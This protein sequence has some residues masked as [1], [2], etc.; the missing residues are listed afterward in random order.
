MRTPSSIRFSA[1][2]LLAWPNDKEVTDAFR[3][4]RY[5]G[6]IGQPRIAL[7]LSSIDAHLRANDPHQPAA[8]IDYSNLQIEH[9]MPQSWEQNWPVVI[10]GERVSKDENDPAWLTASEE[11]IRA[12]NHL[13]NLTLVNGSFNGH[14][15]NGPWASKRAEFAKQNTLVINFPIADTDGWDEGHIRSRAGDLAQ[16]ASLIWQSADALRSFSEPLS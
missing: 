3:N 2:R 11:R 12:V 14:V 8:I 4:N 1:A 9:V 5:Y 10:H 15:S 13:G 6:V 16:V 7:L